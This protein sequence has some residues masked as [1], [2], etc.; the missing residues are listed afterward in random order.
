MTRSG[1]EALLNGHVGG[2]QLLAELTT[3]LNRA[4]LY[5]LL[6]PTDNATAAPVDWPMM[7]TADRL[8][9]PCRSARRV[10]SLPNWV[11]TK[12]TSAGSLTTSA[13]F[14]PPGVSAL[15]SGKVGA[16]AMYPAAATGCR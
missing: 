12:L 9:A 13:R 16:T 4:S 6:K 3:A 5:C 15:V 8:A 10:G 2:R 1:T 11:S 14:G 7:P